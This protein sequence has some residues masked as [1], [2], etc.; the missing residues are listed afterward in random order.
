MLALPRRCSGCQQRVLDLRKP[1]GRL[2]RHCTV[3]RP[4]PRLQEAESAREKSRRGSRSGQLEPHRAEEAR[5]REWRHQ[6]VSGLP[7]RRLQ[8]EVHHVVQFGRAPS[9]IC[10]KWRTDHCITKACFAARYHV[11]SRLRKHCTLCA[12]AWTREFL[13][14]VAWLKDRRTAIRDAVESGCVSGLSADGAENERRMERAKKAEDTGGLHDENF[15]WQKE[16][17]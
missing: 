4:R 8:P 15:R 12:A 10:D 14:H 13:R 3:L 1:R 9:T 6:Q 16:G 2:L 11:R 17:R 5:R 7:Q